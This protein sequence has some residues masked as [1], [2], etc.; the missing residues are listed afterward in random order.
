ML[1]DVL[2]GMVV[3]GSAAVAALVVCKSCVIA[4]G[5]YSGVGALASVACCMS[6][7]TRAAFAALRAEVPEDGAAGPEVVC[8][9]PG[10][11]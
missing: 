11:L 6:R 9:N 7:A 2:L 10:G 8:A 3:G 1:G 4:F 5:V